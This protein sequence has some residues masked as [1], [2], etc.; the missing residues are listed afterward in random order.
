MTDQI[1]SWV[2]AVFVAAA[3][4]TAGLASAP[5]LERWKYPKTV[6]V[7]GRTLELIGAG[8]R[9]KWFFDVYTL[10]AYSESGTCDTLG[11]ISADEVRYIR[12]DLLRNVSAE[13]M[14]K[15]LG[16]AFERNTPADASVDLRIQIETFLSYFQ[17]DLIRGASLELTYVPGP[18][19]TL[20]QNGEQQGAVTPG[21]AFADVL[22]SSYFGSKTCCP[23]LKAQILSHCSKTGS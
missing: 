11:V 19:T 8:L 6:E 17:Q 21:K 7:A 13:N 15:A 23:G 16:K 20:K 2:I 12:I 1:R 18:G 3:L 5:T 14:A 22:W 10:G 9:E 4:A